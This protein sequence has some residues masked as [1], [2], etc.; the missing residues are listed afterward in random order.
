M[1]DVLLGAD[2]FR[3]PGAD[4]ASFQLMALGSMAL[5]PTA[6]IL[7]TRITFGKQDGGRSGAPRTMELEQPVM[8]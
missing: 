7:I 2:T 3:N 8:S 1:I 4:D 5:W 6:M